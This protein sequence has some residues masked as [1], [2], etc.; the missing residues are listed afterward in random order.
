MN[1][2]S[3]DIH[4]K[5]ARLMGIPVYVAR[6]INKLIDNP[7]CHDFFDAALIRSET[8][9]FR[10]IGGRIIT[11]WFRSSRF[12]TSSWKWIREIIDKYGDNG[13]KAFFLH[14]WLD[15]I[16]RNMRSGKG[17]AFL[18]LKDMDYYYKKY[19]D[20]VG[21]FLQERIEDVISDIK[22]YIIAKRISKRMRKQGLE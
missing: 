7:K 16:E 17:F 4:E 15:L 21:I 18:E 11:Y 14:I 6:E 13:W 5:Y 22:A 9:V 19:I 1:M 10:A 8:P 3:W 12:Y 20:E 2:P